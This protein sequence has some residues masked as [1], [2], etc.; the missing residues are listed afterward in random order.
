MPSLSQMIHQ[1]LAAKQLGQGSPGTGEFD[2]SQWA[3]PQQPTAQQ[4]APQQPPT[5]IGDAW[6]WQEPDPNVSQ[7][8]APPEN[9]QTQ[10]QSSFGPTGEPSLTGW[11]GG[12]FPAGNSQAQGLPGESDGGGDMWWEKQ[13][14]WW[15]QGLTRVPER[16]RFGAGGGSP[17][18]INMS[19]SQSQMQ[20]MEQGQCPEHPDAPPHECPGTPE[21]PPPQQPPQQPPPQIPPPQIPPP[22]IP[23]PQIPPPQMPPPPPRTWPTPDGGFDPQVP[24]TPPPTD[25]EFPPGSFTDTTAPG[26]GLTPVG[27]P[28][29]VTG[30]GTPG[31]PG[32]PPTGA[33]G[34]TGPKFPTGTVPPIPGVPQF[35]WPGGRNPNNFWGLPMPSKPAAAGAAPPVAP[36]AAPPGAAPGAPPPAPGA[37]P[38]M[39]GTMPGMGGM[40]PMGPMGAMIPM[41]AI[42]A[43]PQTQWTADEIKGWGDLYAAGIAASPAG[44]A[45]ANQPVMATPNKGGVHVFPGYSNIFGTG[46]TNH[47]RAPYK[48]NTMPAPADPNSL[49]GGAPSNGLLQAPWANEQERDQ[50]LSGGGGALFTPNGGLTPA[51]QQAKA[52]GTL[53]GQINAVRLRA[54][55]PTLDYDGNGSA[56][57]GQVPSQTD[58]SSGSQFAGVSQQQAAPGGPAPGWHPNGTPTAA[59]ASQIG[60]FQK[61]LAGGGS[62]IYN[63]DGTLKAQ[64]QALAANGQLESVVNN[65]RANVGLPPIDMN[66]DGRTNTPSGV[67]ASGQPLQNSGWDPLAKMGSAPPQVAGKF[68]PTAPGW[69]GPK[70]SAARTQFNPNVPAAFASSAPLTKSAAQESGPGRSSSPY[71]RAQG[72]LAANAPAGKGAAGSGSGSSS[73][74]GG[75]TSVAAPT[76]QQQPNINITTTAPS[77]PQASVPN[78][79]MQVYR[80]PAA[81]AAPRPAATATP[82]AATPRPSTT[83]PTAPRP[84]TTTPPRPTTYT[85]P[86]STSVTTPYRPI[87]TYASAYRPTLSAFSSYTPLTAYRAPTYTA[88]TYASTYKAPTYSAPATTYKAPATTTYKAPTTTSSSS[89]Y[90]AP[91]T[92][93]KVTTTAAKPIPKVTAPK[94]TAT[95]IKAPVKITAKPSGLTASQFGSFLK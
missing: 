44:Q 37:P 53:E 95:T 47:S 83:T 74:G 55:L 19:Q 45:A 81:P 40:N 67:A 89:T 31:T 69:T 23:P 92:S 24:P 72:L 78:R 20:W 17:I 32:G 36:P 26:G 29:P 46:D 35:T 59:A 7:T 70:G 34:W 68:N 4:P 64:G 49:L 94:I 18:N 60:E 30:S 38:A 80:R 8:A 3:L 87:T 63:G 12:A 91:T 73:S 41:G 61:F 54:G 16:R 13:A 88:P 33:P 21:Q 1:M 27:G 6:S 39:P 42:P 56:K 93:T 2:P 43:T 58:P 50:V 48:P 57:L 90:K 75:S 11:A 22:Q 28:P 84:T 82:V 85:P 9:S 71:S 15:D 76:K 66:G 77:Q 14:P 51:G 10:M 62:G 79:S 65:I 25:A 5:Q 52:D 86:R